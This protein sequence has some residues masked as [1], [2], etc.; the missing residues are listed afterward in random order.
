MRA[1]AAEA[2]R[3]AWAKS[4]CCIVAMVNLHR[5]VSGE[6]SI[7]STPISMS[8]SVSQTL[9]RRGF[10]AARY[11]SIFAVSE[12]LPPCTICAMPGSTRCTKRCA[13]QNPRKTSFRLVA[14]GSFIWAGLLRCTA[15]ALAKRLRR[16]WQTVRGSRPLVVHELGLRMWI[17]RHNNS[18]TVKEKAMLPSQGGRGKLSKRTAPPRCVHPS[19]AGL[20]VCVAT[21][22]VPAPA[23]IR[24]DYHLSV[25]QPNFKLSSGK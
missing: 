20:R 19:H 18:I 1:G 2:A 14:G 3:N 13:G 6:Q 7:I 25:G 24:R 9:R 23:S 22:G 4:I 16:P 5:A 12:I 21:L 15:N 11:R 17:L 10:P 8:R